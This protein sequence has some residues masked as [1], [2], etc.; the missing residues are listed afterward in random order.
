MLAHPVAEHLGGIAAGGHELGVRAAVAD[1]G[2]RH[3]GVGDLLHRLRRGHDH[4]RLE[5]ALQFAREGDVEQHVERV[6]VL[7][8]GD[9]ADGEALVALLELQAVLHVQRDPAHLDVIHHIARAEQAAARLVDLLHRLAPF[10]IGQLVH[11]QLDVRTGE[12]L[13][14]AGDGV[15]QVVVLEGE[16]RG[17]VRGQRLGVD[18]QALD[19]VEGLQTLDRIGGRI[20]RPAVL[21]Q[22]AAREQRVPDHRA[23]ALA[24]DRL[25]VVHVAGDLRH[26]PA[27]AAHGLGEGLQVALA[28]DVRH[29]RGAVVVGLHVAGIVTRDLG[30][31]P[32]AAGF[33]ALD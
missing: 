3:G 21:V 24:R 20:A 25:G 23:A 18:P 15:G 4:L 16:L 28:H 17:E 30:A 2:K 29:H 33:H 8:L 32:A 27:Q 1:A 11:L 5:A 26:A 19:F 6:L 12:R 22:R 10:G 31:D 7:A 13:L 9:L 14:P